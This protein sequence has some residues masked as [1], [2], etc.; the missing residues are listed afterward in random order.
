ML[1]APDGPGTG[2][3]NPT[4]DGE[5]LIEEARGR[6]ADA[7][8]GGAD[9][10]DLSALKLREIPEALFELTDLRRLTLATNKLAA[11]D[12]R[13]FTASPSCKVSTCLPTC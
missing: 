7:A 6:I 10:L 4:D 5:P 12:L 8:A 2:G 3:G 13:L 9:T 11:L 1:M